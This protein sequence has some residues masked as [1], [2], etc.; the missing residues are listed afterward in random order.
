MFMEM[1][2]QGPLRGANQLSAIFMLEDV[3]FGVQQ[4]LGGS[5]IH[6]DVNPI[7]S[8]AIGD[9][10]DA[11]GLQPLVDE[12][13]SIVRWLDELV[14]FLVGKMLGGCQYATSKAGESWHMQ[15][16]RRK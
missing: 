11:I 16:K 14:D 3:V 12:I 8:G 1:L 6:I 7:H 4:T 15:N 5:D 13:Q 9:V 2:W 10:N